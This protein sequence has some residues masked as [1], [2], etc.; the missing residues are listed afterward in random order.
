MPFL[1]GKKNNFQSF[2]IICRKPHAASTIFLRVTIFQNPEG[3]LWTYCI[4]NIPNK[5][6]NK[7]NNFILKII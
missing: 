7:I 5:C 3:T 2:T 6:G 4:R 1:G